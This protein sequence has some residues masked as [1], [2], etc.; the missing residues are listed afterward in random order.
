MFNLWQCMCHPANMKD[1]IKKKGGN[2]LNK[3]NM[4]SGKYQTS[5][6]VQCPLT[7]YMENVED[8]LDVFYSFSEIAEIWEYDEKGKRFP[9]VNIE[10]GYKVG[11]RF[12]ERRPMR[13]RYIVEF[14]EPITND[15]YDK[16]TLNYMNPKNWK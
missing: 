9:I 15:E 8:N 14:N 2:L 6:Y 5:C 16:I 7:L 12:Y 1:S 13:E 10:E 11:L 3:V 4:L